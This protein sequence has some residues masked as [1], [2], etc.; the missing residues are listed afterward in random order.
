MQFHQKYILKITRK[1][2]FLMIKSPKYDGLPQSMRF[3]TIVS[4]SFANGKVL[5]FIFGH[6]VLQHILSL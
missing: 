1:R 6:L 5:A 4:K 2:V 3:Y